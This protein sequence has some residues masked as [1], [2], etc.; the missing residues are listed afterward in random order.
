MTPQ[1]FD[2][3][4]APVHLAPFVRRFLYANRALEEP[5]PLS[6]KPTG[7]FYFSNFFAPDRLQIK[8][9][10]DD[11]LVMLRAKWNM[12]GQI[13]DQRI[14]GWA[15]KELRVVFC[16]LSATALYRLYGI[17]GEV[18]TGLAGD[19]QHFMPGSE[20][21]LKD[22][23]RLDENASRDE[24]IAEAV[25]YF[26]RL[27][28][29]ARDG[30]KDVER[31]V[32]LYE[33]ANGAVSVADVC[34]ELD[35]SQRHLARK[36]KRIVGVPPRFFGQVLQI[37]WALGLMYFGDSSVLSKIAQDAGFF[38]QAHFNRAMQKFFNESPMEFLKSNHI[39][40]IT[41]LATSRKFSTVD[42]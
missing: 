24:H 22:C 38:D 16:E 7:Y 3:I 37:N 12:A 14:Q 36:F 40:L 35:I 30:D 26:E 29:D 20:T 34:S 31:A 17:H 33:A 39:Q 19:M 23:F 2:I 13:T 21:L 42:D 9:D 5:A 1:F 8:F 25:D 28:V 41:F 15:E 27:I 11:K 32:E 6:P 4:P 10:I 18:M